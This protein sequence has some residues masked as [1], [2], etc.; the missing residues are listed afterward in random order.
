MA[1][2]KLYTTFALFFEIQEWT[3]G[4]VSWDEKECG[5]T[6]VSVPREKIW[7]PDIRINEL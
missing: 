2:A 3:I 6:R 5:T 4:E 1:W 7:V